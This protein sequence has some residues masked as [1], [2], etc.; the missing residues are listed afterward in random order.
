MPW[1]SDLWTGYFYFL[2][3]LFFLTS[4]RQFHF[5]N[6]FFSSSFFFRPLHNFLYSPPCFVSSIFLSTLFSFVLFFL[7]ILF[8]KGFPCVDIDNKNFVL[9]EK[10]KT[11]SKSLYSFHLF[12]TCKRLL[13]LPDSCPSVIP[14]NS[15]L[16]QR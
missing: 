15:L 8:R 10:K 9:S 1:R 16:P 11:D 5:H 2:Y 6:N 13:I 3:H 14:S 12:T 7:C 4:L